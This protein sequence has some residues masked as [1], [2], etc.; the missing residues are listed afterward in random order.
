MNRTTALGLFQRAKVKHCLAPGR[1]PTA[2]ELRRHLDSF[3][4]RLPAACLQEMTEAPGGFVAFTEADT[5]YHPGAWRHGSCAA[6]G[7]AVLNAPAFLED[8]A[9]GLRALAGLLDH[10]LGSLCALPAQFISAGQPYSPHW[11]EF[12]RRLVAAHQ[13]GYADDPAAL[14]SSTGY[15][16]W[17]CARYLVDADDLQAT[18]PQAHRLL[19]S[20]VFSAAF[21]QG[22]PLRPRPDSQAILCPA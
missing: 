10:L 2:W 4:S 16:Q 13:L 5:T 3:L 9:P 11:S 7:V 22:H 15:F 17:A 8:P 14:Q 12:H 1:R 6:Q 18:D 20:T 21:W 19:R